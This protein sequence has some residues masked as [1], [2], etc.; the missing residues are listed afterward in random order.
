MKH[1]ALAAFLTLSAFCAVLYTSCSKDKCKD[2]TCQNG[3]TCSDGNCTCVTGWGGSRCDTA[4]RSLYTNTYVGS[5]TD[6]GTPANTYTNWR[7]VFSTTGTDATKMQLVLQDNTTAAVVALPITLTVT[8]T[9][10]S[11]FTVTSTSANGYT[12]TGTGTVSASTASLI[13]TETSNSNSTVTVYT[14]ANMTKQ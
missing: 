4:Y 3:G 6:N 7:M 13:M 1:V 12:Y 8:A 14:F 5:G 2:V 11:T 10:G 9:T